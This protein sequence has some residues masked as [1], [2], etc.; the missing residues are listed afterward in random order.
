MSIWSSIFSSGDTISKTTDAIIATGDKLV[1]TDEEKADM[2]FKLKEFHIKM[3]EAYHP[4]KLTQ[5]LLALWFSFLFG[6]AFLSA[7]GVT[8][9]NMYMMYKEA[10]FKAISIQP[11]IDVIV[12]FGLFT[13]VIAIVAFYFTGGVIDSYKRGK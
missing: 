8:L 4:F 9:F 2:K 1:Y 12:A 10:T 11:I 7:M 13:I 5:R 6:F 3:L